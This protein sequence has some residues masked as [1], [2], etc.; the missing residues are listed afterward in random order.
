[1]A[2][3]PEARGAEDPLEEYRRKRDFSRTPEPAGD[4]TPAQGP[5]LRYLV[6]KHAASRLHYDLRLEIDGVLKSWAVPKGPS[7]D[8]K[9]KRLAARTEDHPLDYGHFEGTIPEG[10]YGGGT[11][12]LWDE[13]WW[14]PDLDW[15]RES[16]TKK[17]VEAAERHGPGG[18]LEQGELKVRLHGRKLKGS[19]VLVRMRPR[20]GERGENWL[21]IK[22]RD[23]EAREDYDITH[24]EPDSVVS[25]RSLDEIRHA[26]EQGD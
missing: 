7:L 18:M 26:D 3:G 19:W 16:S 12:M 25:G 10:E 22:H 11:V 1:M 20:P 4:E 13:G 15:L 21:L 24:S 6:Q 17:K 8:P 14:Q 2:E 5:R 23:E 9:D